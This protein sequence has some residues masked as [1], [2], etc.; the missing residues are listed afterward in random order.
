LK[1]RP[2]HLVLLGVLGATFAGACDT[3]LALILAGKRC[4]MDR[5][6][7]CLDGYACIDGFCRVP[8]EIVVPPEDD[9]GMGGSSSDGMGGDAQTGIGGTPALGGA[10]S[11]GGTGPIDD[12]PDA[13]VF[14]DGGGDGCVPVDLF[15][16]SDN[17][18]Y[19]DVSRHAFGC[20]R[21]GWVEQPGDCRD[22]LPL[23]NPGQTTFFGQGYDAPGK[24][25]DISFDYDC[26]NVEDGD[27]NNN[28]NAEA[29]ICQGLLGLGLACEGSGYQWTSR[30]N[31]NGVNDLCGS[32]IVITC[33]SPTLAQC[34]GNDLAVQ[35][36]FRCR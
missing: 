5:E 31:A 10:G 34:V 18:G 4:R 2:S 20:I 21:D 26:N 14:L 36:P 35:Q 8:Q 23:V 3:D 9:A 30:G 19:G 28:P 6:P 1:P 32:V 25:D 16:D 22:D 12:I 7:P 13:S 15:L 17:D 27:T 11:Q 24:P 33:I 29:P